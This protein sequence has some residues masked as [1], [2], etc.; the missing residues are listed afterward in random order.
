MRLPLNVARTMCAVCALYVTPIAAEQS[1]KA[2]YNAEFLSAEQEA[3]W[4]AELD[5]L[6][7]S[8]KAK[9][10][11]KV[12][13][14]GKAEA[15]L[16][17]VITGAKSVN[18]LSPQKKPAVR[19]LGSNAV[20]QSVPRRS[21]GGKYTEYA[22]RPNQKPSLLQNH[23]QSAAVLDLWRTP[24]ELDLTG[25]RTAREAMERMLEL[26]GYEFLAE[27]RAVDR[28]A[29]LSLNSRLPA[30]M[31]QM[32]YIAPDLRYGLQAMA[33]PGLIVAVDHASRR[34]SVDM[35]GNGVILAAMREKSQ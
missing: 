9:A 30:A 24:I 6:L 13:G 35:G 8:P 15:A 29:V 25:I 14:K 10:P 28:E 2:H 16:S 5:E 22:G 11:S 21:S 17:P 18:F 12:S 34:V 20:K 23:R 3:Y 32:Q 31:S 4:L 27:G 7:A 19:L 26:V 1:D 33:G